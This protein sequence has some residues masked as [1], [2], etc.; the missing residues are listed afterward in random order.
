M[1][2]ELKASGAFRGKSRPTERVQLFAFQH[3]FN[4][5]AVCVSLGF[6]QRSTVDVYGSGDQCMTH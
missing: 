2:M 5:F 3:H 4:N 1:F 6:H